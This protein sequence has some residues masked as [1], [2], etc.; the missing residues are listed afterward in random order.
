M[1][2]KKPWYVIR[3]AG[4]EFTQ[5]EWAEYLTAVYKGERERIVITFGKYQFNDC[6]ICINPDKQDIVI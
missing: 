6:D 3:C 1:S 4:I 5:D 2:K